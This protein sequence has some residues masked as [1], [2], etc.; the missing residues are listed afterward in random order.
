[1]PDP[2][3]PDDAWRAPHRLAEDLGADSEPHWS[4]RRE[5]RS[6]EPIDE[7]CEQ[8]IDHGQR[9]VRRI[10]RVLAA[11]VIVIFVCAPAACMLSQLTKP[12]VKVTT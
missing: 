9:A 10:G 4:E 3:K 5:V 6:L 8:M 12:V 11:L 7:A 1:M 2:A